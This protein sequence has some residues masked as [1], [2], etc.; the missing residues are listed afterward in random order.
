[1]RLNME[2]KPKPKDILLK[3]NSARL[4]SKG[5]IGKK[6]EVQNGNGGN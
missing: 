5:E 3:V 2:D 4:A 6:K 1:M